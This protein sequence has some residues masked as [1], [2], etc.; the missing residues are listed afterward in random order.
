MGVQLGFPMGYTED[1]GENRE[2]LPKIETQL[3]ISSVFDWVKTRSLSLSVISIWG[4]LMGF[5][6]SSVG[7][8]SA[9]NT[10]DEGSIPGLRR[11]PGE[12]YGNPLQYSCLENPHG[13][14]SL[15]GYSSSGQKELDTTEETQHAHTQMDQPVHCRMLSSLP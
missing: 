15:A 2:T 8:E 10:G 6:S 1:W 14:R 7:K 9:C 13:Q 4:Q 12:G 11:S 3:P 5:P